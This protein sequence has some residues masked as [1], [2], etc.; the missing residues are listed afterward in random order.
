MYFYKITNT[1]S[2]RAVLAFRQNEQNS[3]CVRK[4]RL[5]DSLKLLSL[6]LGYPI[7]SPWQCI[8]KN[9]LPVF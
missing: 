4:K 5:P 6:A 3:L 8:H 9:M 1:I 7:Y 2:V